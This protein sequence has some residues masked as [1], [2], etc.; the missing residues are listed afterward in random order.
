MSTSPFSKQRLFV[1]TVYQTALAAWHR[2]ISVVPIP[3]NGT[4]CPSFS[5]SA[6][7]KRRATASEL[8]SWFRDA[9]NGIALITGAVSG[10][11]EVLDFDTREI[12]QAWSE[13][14]DH[15]GWGSLHARLVQG[16]LEASPNG[17]HL[18]Y[19]CSTIERN[20]KL[21]TSSR[22]GVSHN[23][24]MIETRG[25]G[26]LI[27]V[28]PSCGGVHPSGKPYVVL[29]GKI[30]TIETITP[31]ERQI[32][33]ALA[34]SFHVSP[35]VASVP[36]R[37]EHMTVQKKST[38]QR[39][40][41]L[42]NQ[43]VTWEDVLEPY[44]WTLVHLCDRIGYWRRPGKDFGISATT[45]YHSWDLLYVFSTSTIFEAG[46]WY[47]KFHAYTLL[48]R[49]GDFAAAASALAQQGYTEHL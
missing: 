30:P 31:A 13:R 28:A 45:N 6:Y 37:K 24:T 12:Y 19:R 15:E 16:Y 38:G 39:P 48:E 44:G 7:Q 1:P 40:G 18:L 21:A 41:D 9:R 32:L 34:R 29:Q 20:Q 3:P 36:H 26:G 43:H 5:W 22:E 42:Y 25:E 23:K 4:K 49:R 2:G 10:G 8:R 17:I 47:S 33:L 27:V 11:L 46:R 35:I 14:M